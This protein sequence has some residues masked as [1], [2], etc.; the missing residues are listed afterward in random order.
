MKW[1]ALAGLFLMA[2]SGPA[3]K[4]EWAVD[5][6]DRPYM[7]AGLPNDVR[8]F[9]VAAR[10]CGIRQLDRIVVHDQVNPNWDWVIVREVLAIASSSNEKVQCA[11]NWGNA[12][13][14]FKLYHFGELAKQGTGGE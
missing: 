8:Q 10:N 12:H 4:T 3:L 11:R 2:C 5:D 7:V 9:E 13:P 14:E 6:P 1:V